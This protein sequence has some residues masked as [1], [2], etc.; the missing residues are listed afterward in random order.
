MT[1]TA[2]FKTR[3]SRGALLA[4]VA[5]WLGT[6][7]V[8]C[9]GGGSSSTT[10]QATSSPT[11]SPAASAITPAV[12]GW[13]TKTVNGV[14]EIAHG[15]GTY[16]PQCA[17]FHLNSGYF[18]MNYATGSGWGTSIVVLPSLWSNG[19]Y[20]QGAAVTVGELGVDQGDLIV[21]FTGT[22][23]TLSVRGSIRVKAP[24]NDAVQAAVT[25]SDVT[26]Y[27]TLDNRTGEAFK[28]LL[29][30]SMRIDADHYDASAAFVGTQDF[31]IPSNGWMI[32]PPAS[33][34]HFGLRGGTSS[35]KIDAPT[36]EIDLPQAMPVTGWVTS[37]TNPND[38][39]IGMW[40]ASDTIMRAWT[41]TITTKKP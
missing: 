40:S 16:Y 29:L 19:T 4:V 32:T 1:A 41:Y 33:G 9:G 38:D 39:N 35:W 24:A 25:V 36:V 7:L 12:A 26:G 20:Y 22:I 18:R 6:I 17:A 30:S 10:T 11:P 2:G 31:T 37:S 23:A 8:G 21:P 5:G 13:S 27:V 14:L 3:V 15:S 34:A 28:P